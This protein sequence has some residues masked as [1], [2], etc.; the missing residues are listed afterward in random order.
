MAIKIITDFRVLFQKAHALGQ[1][2]KSGDTV[3][4][5]QAQIEHDKYKALCLRSDQ[6]ML[7]V[8]VEAL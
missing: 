4:I 1:A 7:G 3:K 6:I 8:S 5:E 2:K